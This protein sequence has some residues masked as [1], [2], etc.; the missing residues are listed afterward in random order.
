MNSS[1]VKQNSAL[2]KVLGIKRLLN[3]SAQELTRKATNFKKTRTQFKFEY[4][5]SLVNTKPFY[6]ELTWY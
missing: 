6:G 4:T 3:Y 5:N 2:H 1:E